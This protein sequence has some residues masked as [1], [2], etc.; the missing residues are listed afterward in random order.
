MIEFKY[1]LGETLKDKITGFTGVAMGRTE[2]LTGCIQYGLLSRKLNDK[3]LVQ[4]WHWF[5]EERVERVNTKIIKLMDS[6]GGPQP[7]PP[8]NN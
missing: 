7:T 3:G 6:I 2:Y 5:D 1:S 8:R 4:D